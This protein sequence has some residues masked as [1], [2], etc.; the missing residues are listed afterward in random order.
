MYFE[1]FFT[2]LC[3][4]FAAAKWNGKS[5]SIMENETITKVLKQIHIRSSEVDHGHLRYKDMFQKSNARTT[6]L[7]LLFWSTGL[8]VNKTLLFNSTKLHGNLFLNYIFAS[9]LT[10][11]PGIC[12]LTITMKYFD[13]RL[14]LFA[15]LTILAMS[16]AVLAFIPKSVSIVWTWIFSFLLTIGILYHSIQM[17]YWYSTLLEEV[18]LLQPCFYFGEYL[19]KCTLQI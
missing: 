4:D 9:A 6:I 10:D 17:S 7:L 3:S 8:I 5:I 19:L 18:Q 13:R 2:F 14:N 1:L 12:I 16:T 15:T 11:L